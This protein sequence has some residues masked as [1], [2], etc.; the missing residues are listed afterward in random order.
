ME[1]TSENRKTFW[2]FWRAYSKTLGIHQYLEEVNLQTKTRVAT[3][4]VFRVWKGSQGCGEQV[5]VG[6]VS[7]ALGGVNVKIAQYTGQQPLHQPG[8]NEKYIISLLHMIKRFENKDPQQVKK[9]AVY[10]D[11]PDWLCKWGHKKESLPQQ[12]AVGDLDM[13]D[14]Y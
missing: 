13:V 5:Q 11:L 6:T 1:A 9:L 10:P 8:P 4:S 2:R 12:Q 3:G 14:F 7:A